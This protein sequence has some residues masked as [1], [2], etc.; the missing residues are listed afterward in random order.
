[1]NPKISITTVLFY[2]VQL[3]WSQ[4]LSKNQQKT[5]SYDEIENKINQSETYNTKKQFSELYLSRAKTEQNPIRI[6]D[7]FVFMALLTFPDTPSINYA[8]SV[9]ITTRN[10]KNLK[11]PALGYNLKG[12]TYYKLGDYKN[13]LDNYLIA[14]NFAKNNKNQFQYL[15]LKFNIGL[16]KNTLGERDEAQ[17]NFKEYLHFLENS[18]ENKFS[19]NYIIGLYALA[20]SYT[21]SKKLDSAEIFINK[22]IS[23]TLKKSDGSYY[24]Y[25]VLNSGINNYFKQ[26]FDVAID[27]LTRAK[28]LFEQKKNEQFRF[29]IC[30]YYLAKSYLGLNQKKIALQYFVK[31]DSALKKK[32]DISPILID[33]YNYLID[34]AKQNKNLE[35]QIEYV[36]SLIKFDSILNQNYRYLKTTIVKKYETPELISEKEMLIK[37]LNKQQYLTNQKSY[38]LTIAL[39]SSSLILIYFVRRNYLNKKRFSKILNDIKL[40]ESNA[41][42]LT[43]IASIE[44]NLTVSEL[45][46]EILN[47]I[48]KRLVKFENS[49]RFTTK[50]YTLNSLAKEL[51][52]NSS[53]LSKVINATK[54]VNFSHYLNN[55][56]I[57]YSINRLTN[58]KQFRSYTIKAISE[59]SGFNNA[60]SF[61]VAF[62]KKTGIYPS[63]FIKKI[64]DDK[65]NLST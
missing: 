20:D 6:A 5:I 29:A 1:V 15:T 43:K 35:K 24:S 13:A 60:Q 53:Y 23:E 18:N 2:L 44:I 64:N 45:P 3:S 8:D 34:D 47:D 38:L 26:N 19:Q 11:Y 12:S 65:I 41:L 54:K 33:T 61:S 42:N 17:K 58:D 31:V 63:Y 36:T 50:K 16:L 52:T 59:E 56:R 4:N 9:I 22:G 40:K 25:F 49:T 55:L 57:D 37:Q 51:N 48:L 39:F 62:Y 28:K 30:D 10:L 21:Y 14:L 46:D 7:G 32:N 27:N